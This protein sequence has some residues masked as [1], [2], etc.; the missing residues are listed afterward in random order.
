MSILI[1]PLIDLRHFPDH[2]GP[3]PVPINLAAET[4]NPDASNLRISELEDVPTQGDRS[5]ADIW[6]SRFS[7]FYYGCSE[8]SRRFTSAVQDRHSKHYLM[9][10]ASGGLNQQRTG[11][12][13]L[14]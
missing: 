2:S 10:A 12:S 13:L 11:V 9:I 1:G 14:S 4:R 3:P 5:I 7:E 8:P 6:A